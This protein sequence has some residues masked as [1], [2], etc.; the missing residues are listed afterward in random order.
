MELLDILFLLLIFTTIIQKL[1]ESA[2]SKANQA[3]LATQGFAIREPSVHARIIKIFSITWLIAML[4]E[5]YINQST[6]PLW[7]RISAI[8]AYL[9]AQILR[10]WTLKS[11][12]IHWNTS[13]LAPERVNTPS[14]G[15]LTEEAMVSGKTERVEKGLQDNLFVESGPYKYIRH[16]YNLALIIEIAALPICGNALLTAIIFS[17]W[18]NHLLNKHIDLEES[19]LFSRP[20]Y[21]ELFYHKS[22]FIPF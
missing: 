1:V 18:N 8:L 22:R 9:L 20:G 16:P 21:H 5:W 2:Y 6:I 10:I 7:L 11:L 14:L 4:S 15:A 19:W 13:I 12:G 17:I 3:L